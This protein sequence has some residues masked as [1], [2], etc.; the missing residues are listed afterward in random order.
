MQHAADAVRAAVC[1]LQ[2]LLP[3]VFQ[4]MGTCALCEIPCARHAHVLHTNSLP[5]VVGIGLQAPGRDAWR[6]PLKTNQE[7]QCRVE[8][9]DGVSP[10][11]APQ[12]TT[13]RVYR[14]W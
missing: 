10:C 3:L 7:V 8:E 12:T 4:S 6:G 1:T 11:G 2:L 14:G 9:W 5:G 13:V